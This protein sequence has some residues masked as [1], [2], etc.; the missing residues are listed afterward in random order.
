MKTKSLLI[1]LNVLT[2]IVFVAL[3]IKAGAMLFLY[4][5]SLIKPEVAG[6]LYKGLNMLDLRQTDFLR[7]S[8]LSIGFASLPAIQAYIAHIM[9]GIFTKM[10][11]ESPFTL[12][13]ADRLRTISLLILGL[14]VATFVTKLLGGTLSLTTDHLFM[15]GLTF[16]ISEIFRR[17]VDMQSEQELTV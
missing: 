14:W 15:A 6:H 17:G 8:A 16:L 7:Y 3:L 5:Y 10:N 4:G 13:T 2:W 1:I 12:E 11:L 9:I